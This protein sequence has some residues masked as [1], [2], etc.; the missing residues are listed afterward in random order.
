MPS[1]GDVIYNITA[2]YVAALQADNT[3]GTPAL[4]EYGQ[5]FPI[6]Y[7]ADNDDLSGYGMTVELLSVIRKGTATFKNGSFNIA[8]KTIITGTS[9]STSGTTP[10]QIGTTDFQAGGAGLP[11]FGLVV[12]GAST[13]GNIVAGYPKCKL[14]TIPKFNIMENKFVIGEAKIGMIAP[15]TT[16]RKFQRIKRY[17]TITA[18][19]SDASGFDTFFTGMFDA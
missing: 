11:Y 15:S 10:N 5:E 3:Y 4:V 7:E 17:E 8:S 1:Y 12:A 18:P 9:E 16:I 2:M 6:D 13:L 19:P 14:E